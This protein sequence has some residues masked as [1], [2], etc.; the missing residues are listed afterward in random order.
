MALHRK[1]TRGTLA[2]SADLSPASRVLWPIDQAFILTM[3]KLLHKESNQT[4]HTNRTNH[5]GATRGKS[6]CIFKCRGQQQRAGKGAQKID[7]VQR[8]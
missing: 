5:H 8:I 3:E 2:G 1:I 4:D 6:G 7:Q